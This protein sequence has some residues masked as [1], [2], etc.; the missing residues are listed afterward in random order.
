MVINSHN[1]MESYIKLMHGVSI[2]IP[3]SLNGMLWRTQYYL[4]NKDSILNAITREKSLNSWGRCLY[5]NVK[6]SKIIQMCFFFNWRMWF[7]GK[8]WAAVGWSTKVKINNI[9]ELHHKWV[10]IQHLCQMLTCIDSTS[11]AIEEWWWGKWT[12][13]IFSL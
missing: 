12:N 2:N 13:E 8:K 9:I 3:H 5:H 7:V 6:L 1:V 4:C 11:L 10:M